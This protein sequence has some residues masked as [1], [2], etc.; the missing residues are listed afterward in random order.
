[1]KRSMEIFLAAGALAAATVH[2]KAADAGVLKSQFIYESAPFPECHASTIA[3]NRGGTGRRLVRRHAGAASG[4]GD[5]GVAPGGRALE[6]RPSRSP[7]APGSPRTDSPLEPSAVSAGKPGRCCSSTRSAPA[8]ASGGHADDFGR[9]RPDLVGAAAVAGR[10]PRADQE[11]TGAATEWR[12]AL[13][14]QHGRR[15]LAGALREHQR[16]RAHLARHAA[17]E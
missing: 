9:R 4:R 6:R 7:T 11:Q 8:R 10:H 1:M 14:V 5:L 3:E 2:G 16:S 12:S 17:G 13:S 15:G